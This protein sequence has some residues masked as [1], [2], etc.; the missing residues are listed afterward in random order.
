MATT[1]ERLQTILDNSDG[2]FNDPK[3]D[4]PKTGSGAGTLEA[5][6][7]PIT[8]IDDIIKEFDDNAKFFVADNKPISFDIAPIPIDKFIDA[9]TEVRKAP[10]NEQLSHLGVFYGLSDDNKIVLTMRGVKFDATNN[11]ENLHKPIPKKNSS[12]RQFTTLDIEPRPRRKSDAIPIDNFINAFTKIHSGEDKFV[13]VAYIKFAPLM[14]RLERLQEGGFK[15]LKIS[16]GFIA[17][18]NEDDLNCFHVI[19]TGLSSQTGLSTLDSVFSTL[20][21][22]TGYDGPKP[23]CPPFGSLVEDGT[24]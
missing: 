20:S 7:A 9:M 24:N 17:A 15:E 4:P 14:E 6:T 13:I 16:F 18:K 22:D 11:G 3:F 21:S 2:I 12:A 8:T 19:F 5:P 10:S 1:A 23:S